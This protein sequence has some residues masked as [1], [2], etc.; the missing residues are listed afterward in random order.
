M[1][2]VAPLTRYERLRRNIVTP[3][4]IYGTLLVGSLVAVAEEDEDPVVMLILV[5]FAVGVFYLA[6]VFAGTIAHRGKED[7]RILPITHAIEHSAKHSRG[8]LYAG[9][10][11]VLALVPGAFGLIS[12]EASQ[13]L[14]LLVVLISLIVMGWQAMAERRA[15]WYGRLLGSVVCGLFGMFVIVLEA[16]T[17]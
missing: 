9:V 14:A 17:H 15:R 3:E 7:E 5:A 8:L 2:Q 11:P 16:V 10:L 6:H 12:G 1:D 4:S 13:D